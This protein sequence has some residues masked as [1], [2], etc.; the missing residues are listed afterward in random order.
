MFTIAW[1]IEILRLK[2][3]NDIAIQSANRRVEFQ[4]YDLKT[5]QT[6]SLLFFSFFSLRS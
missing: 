4:I 2:P 6:G 1:I 5:Q 3:Q